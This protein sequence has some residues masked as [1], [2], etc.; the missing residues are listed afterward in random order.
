MK[1]LFEKEYTFIL[2]K[3]FNKKN[4]IQMPSKWS[5]VLFNPSDE[6]EVLIKEDRYYFSG[7]PG[8]EIGV[9]ILTHINKLL[10]EKEITKS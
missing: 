3:F 7:K 1:E 2:T 6:I 10:K 4:S 8:V 5:I 9:K